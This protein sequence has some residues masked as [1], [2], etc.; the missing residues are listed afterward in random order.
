MALFNIKENRLIAIKQTPFKPEKKLQNLVEANLQALAQLTFVKSEFSLKGY[1]IDTLAFDEKAKAFVI[2]EYKVNKNSSV[3]DQGFTYLNLLL[4]NKAEFI[5]EYNEKFSKKLKRNDVDWSQTR[6]IFASPSFT[7]FQITSNN[8]RDNGIE[9]WEVKHYE[10]NLLSINTIKKDKNAP[11]IKT[12]KSSSQ[13]LQTVSQEIK[14]YTEEQHIEKASDNIKELYE[15]FKSAILNLDSSI[16]VVPLKQYISFKTT[17]NICDIEINKGSL[18]IFLNAK[19]GT[20]DDSKKL[21]E[22]VSNKGHHGNGD[23][24]AKVLDNKNLEYIIS[25]LK[26]LL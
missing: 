13:K 26:Q 6:V 5:L 20:L 25:V 3:V 24:K 16:E 23:Y 4:S 8:F 19:W 21:F 11:S 9:L 1:R 2:I 14:V 7:D 22:N 18:Y 10:N 15:E 12:L 17:S